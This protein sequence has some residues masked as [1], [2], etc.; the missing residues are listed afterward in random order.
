MLNRIDMVGSYLLCVINIVLITYLIVDLLL[1]KRVGRI[2][3]TK[4]VNKEISKIKPS[5][6]S[7]VD[8]SEF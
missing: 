7:K 5:L 8:K 1:L 4:Y 2:I 3:S 6:Y